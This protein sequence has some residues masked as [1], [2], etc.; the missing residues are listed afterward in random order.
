MSARNGIIQNAME[1]VRKDLRILQ[2][3]PMKS[4]C[5][6]SAR[7]SEINFNIKSKG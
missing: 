6:L 3:T 4:I 7:N 5:A 2:K 1:S